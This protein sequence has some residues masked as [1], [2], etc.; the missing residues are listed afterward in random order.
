M[1]G[2]RL[3]LLNSHPL[4][5][6]AESLLRKAGLKPNPK[7]LHSLSLVQHYLNSPAG[8]RASRP[9][10]DLD[11][12]RGNLDQI[13]EEGDPQ[14]A[15]MLLADDQDQVEKDRSALSPRAM[16]DKHL[17]PVDR[18]L[19]KVNDPEQAGLTLTENLL[20][21]LE[22]LSSINQPGSTT[23]LLSDLPT[24]KHLPMSMSKQPRR[25]EPGS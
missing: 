24:Q 1:K 3:T 17:G 15:Q 11:K 18:R 6:R 12:V 19:A 9:S 13:Q 23:P 22:G 7:H 20:D 14:E 5:R 21:S 4:N 16:V 8:L 2:H 10:I 25:V